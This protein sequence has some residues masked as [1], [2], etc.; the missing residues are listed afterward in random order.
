METVIIMYVNVNYA[1]CAQTL[2][3]PPPRS[4]QWQTTEHKEGQLQL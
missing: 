3:P 1:T 2:F 4:E